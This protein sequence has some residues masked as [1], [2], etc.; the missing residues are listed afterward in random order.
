MAAL[1]LAA[2]S[3]GSSRKVSPTTPAP[4]SAPPPTTVP[5]TTTTTP[6]VTGPQTPFV[7]RPLDAAGIATYSALLKGEIQLAA[8]Y[9]TQAA[10]VDPSLV[11]LEDDKGLQPAQ[12]LVPIGRTVIFSPPVRS[13][14]NVI[15]HAL[16]D[17]ELRKLNDAVERQGQSV[18]AA[19]Q[20]W[21]DRH[22]GT[23]TIVRAKV[24]VATTDVVEQ[25][26]V[27]ALYAGALRRS[28]AD[29]TLQLALGSRDVVAA[30]L[31]AGTVDL[32]AEYVG[33]YDAF[34]GGSPTGDATMTYND[35]VVRGRPLDLEIGLMAEASDADAIATTAAVA[36]RFGLRTV[37]D[38]V[39]VPEPLVFG[40]SPQCP[41][42]DTCLLGYQRAYG[43]KF[44]VPPG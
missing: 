43:L 14:L 38:L 10:L 24:R 17:E 19:A 33:G 16:D 37:S 44:V 39:H 6:V 13:V 42:L 35:L 20:Q 7:F 27:G 18:E 30:A 34:L 21:L 32:T 26:I 12:N 3:H 11:V 4:T 29:V 5:A 23:S 40:G 8:V 2:C 28:G 15:S 41:R 36:T 1:L 25:Q 31:R 9:S 22:I